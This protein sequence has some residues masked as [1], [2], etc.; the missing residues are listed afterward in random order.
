MKRRLRFPKAKALSV[1]ATK[2]LDIRTIQTIFVILLGPRA[3][4]PSAGTTAIVQRMC[5]RVVQ[6]FRTPQVS[7]NAEIAGVCCMMETLSDSKVGGTVD[8]RKYVWTKEYGFHLTRLT[9][10]VALI[11]RSFFTVSPKIGSQ[12]S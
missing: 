12:I 3:S 6:A 5:Q 11:D 1:P 7:T 2:V 8:D 4:S 10:S 9:A